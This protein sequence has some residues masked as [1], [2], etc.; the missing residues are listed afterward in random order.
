MTRSPE[1][2]PPRRETSRIGRLESGVEWG[3]LVSR[4]LVLIPVVVLVVS[5]AATFVYG[6]ALFI[7]TARDITG[8]P[9]PVGN[10]IGLFLLVIDLFLVGAT[11][12]ISAIGFYELFISR[13]DTRGRGGHLPEWLVMR[14]LNDLKARVVSM[15]I[16]VAAATFVDVVVDFHGGDDILFLGAAVALVIA[17]LTGF[18]R[19]GTGGRDGP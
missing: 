19:F 5:A 7:R 6:S 11:L 8:H 13:I 16:L 15:L 3:L 12:L 14:D 1:P 9:F 4:G 18:L 2:D 10:K 17:A